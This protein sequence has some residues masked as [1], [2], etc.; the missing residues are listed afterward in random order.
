MA[1][2]PEVDVGSNDFCFP[3][4]VRAIGGPCQAKKFTHCFVDGRQRD[5]LRANSPGPKGS[6]SS[7][8][9]GTVPI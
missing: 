8:L 3:P 2:G 5:G 4:I 1:I 7:G 9:S 6:S